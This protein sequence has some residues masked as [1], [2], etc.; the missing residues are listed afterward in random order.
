MPKER[1]QAFLTP[2]PPA[3]LDSVSTESRMLCNGGVPAIVPFVKG[4]VGIS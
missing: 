1:K 4:S 2:Y 3:V